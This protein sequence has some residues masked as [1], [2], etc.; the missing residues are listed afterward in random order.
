MTVFIFHIMLFSSNIIFFWKQNGGETHCAWLKFTPHISQKQTSWI[1]MV[2]SMLFWLSQCQKLN[3]AACTHSQ[4]KASCYHRIK[5]IPAAL[6]HVSNDLTNLHTLHSPVTL[7]KDTA[8]TEEWEP[9]VRFTAHR[10][11]VQT[12][13]WQ[14]VSCTHWSQLKPQ[15]A[16]QSADTSQHLPLRQ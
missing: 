15:Q 13:S 7:R 10:D 14:S 12:W 9:R 6:E 2:F 8:L 3:L 1:F 11:W 5:L 16:G 4:L